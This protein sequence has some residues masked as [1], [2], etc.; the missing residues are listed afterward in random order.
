MYL[1][2]KLHYFPTPFQKSSDNKQV[3]D[4]ITIIQT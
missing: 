3:L 4:V 2:E 1:K